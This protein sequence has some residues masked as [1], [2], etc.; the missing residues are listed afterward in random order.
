MSTKAGRGTIATISSSSNQMLRFR[1]VDTLR[2]CISLVKIV[3]SDSSGIDLLIC[4]VEISESIIKSARLIATILRSKVLRRS[5]P[6]YMEQARST[7]R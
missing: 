6:I 2:S 4:H 3:G 5:A 7:L 1:V